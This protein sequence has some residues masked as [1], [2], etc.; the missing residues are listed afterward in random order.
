MN[1]TEADIKAI[2]PNAKDAH[3]SVYLPFLNSVLS[4][5][6]ITTPQRFGAFVSQVGV[7]SIDFSDVIE[8]ASGEEYEGREDLGNTQKGDGVKFKGRGLIQITGRDTYRAASRR[9]F[10]NDC[11]LQTPELITTPQYALESACW[12]WTY[13]KELNTVTDQEEDWH[14]AGPHNFNK[15]EWLSMK[16][17]GGFNGLAERKLNYI[18]AR[19]HFNF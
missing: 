13:Y 2:L 17:N 9:L 7:E 1:F 5:Y 4:K 16:V 19:Q 8:N 3:L 18:R 6:F 12:F 11:L 14:R 15:I 10:G